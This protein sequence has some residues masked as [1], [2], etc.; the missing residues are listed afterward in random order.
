MA[1]KYKETEDF[2]K[3]VETQKKLARKAR[4]TY[5]KN[6]IRYDAKSQEYESMRRIFLDEQAGFL[7]RS[8]AGETMSCMRRNRTSESMHSFYP[9]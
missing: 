2:L 3:G 4:E 9:S 1:L 8:L 7:A 5:Q 6:R